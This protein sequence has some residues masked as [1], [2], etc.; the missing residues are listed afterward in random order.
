M[1]P[2]GFDSSGQPDPSKIDILAIKGIKE[3]NS[4]L[5]TDLK[6]HARGLGVLQNDP[7]ENGITLCKRIN[8]IL[9]QIEDGYE[10]VRTTFYI[11]RTGG[12]SNRVAPSCFAF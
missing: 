12:K 7:N 9:K 1:H 3:K 8:N 10:N 4:R 2:E 5:C 11:L 6:N